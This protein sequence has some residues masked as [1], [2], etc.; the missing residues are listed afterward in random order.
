ME[1]TTLTV[2][3]PNSSD[4]H[5]RYQI[6]IVLDVYGQV[7]VFREIHPLHPAV[8]QKEVMSIPST[9]QIFCLYSAE[10]LQ[11]LRR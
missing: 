2:I 8:L 11:D 3:F 6:N 5:C 7:W 10:P 1:G 4:L 9:L